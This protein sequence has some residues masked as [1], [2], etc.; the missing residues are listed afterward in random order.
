[1]TRRGAGF[2]FGA[3]ALF[4]LGLALA[5]ATSPRVVL[6][7]FR[8]DGWNPR[9]WLMFGGAQLVTARATAWLLRAS[10]KLAPRPSIQRPGAGV[11][12]PLGRGCTPGGTAL[13]PAPHRPVDTRLVV[14]ALVFGAGWGLAGVCPGPAFAAAAS[15][16]P[17]ALLALAGLV[18]GIALH[19]ARDH[20]RPGA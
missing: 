19:D 8:L 20:F 3:G 12:A 13:R 4:A 6:D 5:G 14:G 17:H 1:M 18:A 15:T 7:A 2:A 9:L 11:P 10:I 16:G